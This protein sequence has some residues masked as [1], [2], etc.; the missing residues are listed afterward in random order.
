MAPRRISYTVLTLEVFVLFWKV[1]K[2]A[3][4]LLLEGVF[5]ILLWAW[6]VYIQGDCLLSP[7][8]KNLESGICNH[9]AI[10]WQGMIWLCHDSADNAK[11]IA[12]WA[13]YTAEEA[14]QSVE[15]F[16]NVHRAL[17]STSQHHI[18]PDVKAHTCTPRWTQEDCSFKVVLIYIKT[19]SGGIREMQPQK[20]KGV[21]GIFAQSVNIYCP[22]WF[23]K[24]L[25]GQ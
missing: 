11:I 14:A 4:P 10:C 1:T 16:S 22:D 3:F 13:Y 18:K 6:L 12:L 21:E 9:Q 8:D 23:T 5:V 7:E 19:G 17:S 24:D 20:N 2:I 15:R 25:N